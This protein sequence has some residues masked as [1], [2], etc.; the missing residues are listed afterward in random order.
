MLVAVYIPTF[1][2]SMGQ[3]ILIPTLPLYAQTYV[4]SFALVS[5][6]VAASGIGTLLADVPVGM[7]LQRAGRKP[8]MLVGTALVAV[9]T[10]TLAF[11]QTYPELLAFRFLAGIGNAMWGI[12]R[13]AYIAEVVP[14]EDRGRAISSFGGINRIGTF[15]GPAV[16]GIIGAQFGLHIPFIVTSLLAFCAL[17]IAQAFVVEPPGHGLARGAMRWRKVG[18]IARRQYQDLATAGAAQVFAA[19]IRS[20]RQIIIPLYGASVVGLDVAQ[21]GTI[22][23]IA[24]AIDMSLFVPA[25]LLMDRLGRK[26]ASVPSFLIMGVG[27][28][29]VP[30]AG[31]YAGLLLATSVMAFGNGIGSGTMMTL[32]ADLAPKEATG[33]FLGLWRLIGD[34]G[35]TSG[36]MVVGALGDIFGLSI[37]AFSLAGIGALAAV[38]LALFVRETLTAGDA[39][40]HRVAS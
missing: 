6:V 20:G 24:A 12:S 10:L 14:I 26:F 21:V 31:D 3:G 32:G 4:P 40:V 1:L 5:I 35:Q 36:P 33:E 28:G 34:I 23:S 15:V 39:S 9:F 2:L 11:A 22:I 8:L 38:T 27:M 25:G 19:M 18:E 7:A 17:G 37:A 16:G 30:L 29:L 13:M